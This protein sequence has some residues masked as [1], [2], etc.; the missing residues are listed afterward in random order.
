MVE[1]TWVAR[2]VWTPKYPDWDRKSANAN[3]VGCVADA[4]VA[5]RS[6]RFFALVR[7]LDVLLGG[8]AGLSTSTVGVKL[9]LFRTALLPTRRLEG[10]VG[11]FDRLVVDFNFFGRFVFLLLE[12]LLPNVDSEEYRRVEQQ[13]RHPR[14]L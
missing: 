13:E 14:I 6:T 1:A 5:L 7:L 8:E 4:T 12:T 11:L 2:C 10:T 9:F 3:F